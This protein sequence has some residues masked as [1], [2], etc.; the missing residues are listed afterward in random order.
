M[1]E[2]VHVAVRYVTRDRSVR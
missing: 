2:D 1:I